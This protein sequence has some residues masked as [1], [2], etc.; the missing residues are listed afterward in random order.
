MSAIHHLRPAMQEKLN[1]AMTSTTLYDLSSYILKNDLSQLALGVCDILGGCR[2]SKE[3]FPL[4]KQFAEQ[5]GKSLLHLS[6]QS[7]SLAIVHCL[8][9]VGYGWAAL[10]TPDHKGVSP[11]MLA[12]KGNQLDILKY[13][14]GAGAM[15]ERK[16]L[17]L[18]SD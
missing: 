8:V 10:N 17:H 1:N 6:V 3:K 5:G 18:S 9:M 14:I 2:H 13:L 12:A 4:D 7:N 16:H 11:L 15:I